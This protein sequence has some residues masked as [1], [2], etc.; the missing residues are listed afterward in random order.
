MIIVK[1]V[2]F[3]ETKFNFKI[4]L[5]LKCWVIKSENCSNIWFLYFILQK[6]TISYEYDRYKK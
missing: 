6:F 3:W 5:I 2:Y 1:I 4:A